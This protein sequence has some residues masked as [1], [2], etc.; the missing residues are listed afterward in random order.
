MEEGLKDQLSVWLNKW[1]QTLLQ[2]KPEIMDL[3]E[4]TKLVANGLKQ[5][6]NQD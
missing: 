4:Q 2:R 6:L 3:E 1:L 5:I